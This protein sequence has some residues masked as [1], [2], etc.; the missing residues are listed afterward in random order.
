MKRSMPIKLLPRLSSA[1]ALLLLLVFA[2][3]CATTPLVLTPADPQADLSVYK[4]LFIKTT[5][6]GA[7]V[8]RTAQ[9]RIKDLV[10][11]ELM[12]CC[13]QRFAQIAI[14]GTEPHDLVLNLKLTVYDEGN[15]FARLMLAGLGSMQ[16]HAQVEL[17]DGDSA[18]VL[19]AG[20]A[21]KTFAWGG[22]YG[23]VT[24]IEDIEKDFAKEVVK[25]LRQSLGIQDS[26]QG[27][28]S[29]TQRSTGHE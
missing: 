22:V 8:S 5:A 10:R 25:G 29:V 19:T 7:L 28:N 11:T 20:E 6:Q 4:S 9:E 26:A 16:I 18:R 21:G 15:R 13:A 12:G 24:G 1:S 3:G 23:A 27:E 2:T 14:D 17:L